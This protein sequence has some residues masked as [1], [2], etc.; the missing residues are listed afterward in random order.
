M[1]SALVVMTATLSSSKRLG[2]LKLVSLGTSLQG[3]LLLRTAHCS[4]WRYYCE[5]EE[6]GKTWDS[7]KL[8][9]HRTHSRLSYKRKHSELSINQVNVLNSTGKLKRNGEAHYNRTCVVC[10]SKTKTT[11]MARGRPRVKLNG[12]PYMLTPKWFHSELEPGASE[13]K[14]CHAKSYYEKNREWI[15]AKQKWYYEQQKRRHEIIL[16]SLERLA[17]LGKKRKDIIS[18]SLL[19]SSSR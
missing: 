18:V 15:R 17:K 16:K 9:E 1:I 8:E 14:K 6:E 2:F 5:K 7:Q 11:Y 12:E 19:E 4:L 10:N 3:Y 13:C